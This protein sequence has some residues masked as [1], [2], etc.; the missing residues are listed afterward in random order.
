MLKWLN[1]F[2]QVLF[3]SML[4]E[5][6]LLQKMCEMIGRYGVGYKPPSYHDIR[7]KLLK[8]AVQ[9]IDVILEEFKEEWKRNSCS[10]MSDGWISSE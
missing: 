7:E 8:Q 5:I 2:T 9:K 10:I 3:H 1:F 4:L 6:L